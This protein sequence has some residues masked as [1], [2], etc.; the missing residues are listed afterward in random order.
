VV[1]ALPHI[2]L[3]DR[4]FAA[5]RHMLNGAAAVQHLRCCC[6]QEPLRMSDCKR[7][8]YTSRRLM[9]SCS[10]FVHLETFVSPTRGAFGILVDTAAAKLLLVPDPAS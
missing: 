2:L 1:T 5:G 4:S 9:V 3:L 7:L 8:E 6:Q 10:S